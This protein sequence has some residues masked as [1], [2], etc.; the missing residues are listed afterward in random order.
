MNAPRTLLVACIALAPLSAQTTWS[1]CA[2]DAPVR[3]VG[4][5]TTTTVRAPWPAS[6]RLPAGDYE[7]R[8][9]ADAAGRPLA[10]AFSVPDGAA[11]RVVAA[12]AP[13]AAAVYVALD[14]P[15]WRAAGDVRWIADAR[16]EVLVEA[17]YEEAA[18]VFG[19][20]ARWNGEH[21]HYRFVEDRERNELRLER[22]HGDMVLVLARAPASAASPG[23][24]RLAL[25]VVGF[26]LVALRDD[27]VVLQS[28]DGAFAA[29]G[30]GLFGGPGVTW[31]SFSIAPPAAS[32]DSAAAVVSDGRVDLRVATIA[33]P[34]SWHV[35][36]LSLD[37]PGP[38]APT[39]SAGLAPWL[40]LAA[41]ERVLT[42]DLRGTLGE[43]TVGEVPGA[44]TFRTTLRWPFLPGLSGQF[45]VVRALFVAA[46]GRA[47]EGASPG[48]PLVF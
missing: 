38:L 48:V 3:I 8:F 6:V 27:A 43:G 40:L 15:E 46:D 25:Q 2:G 11:V 5:A 23:P 30:C 10:T 24:H 45:V 32:R 20:V 17:A 21:D 28:L 26:R 41:G 22:R 9:A 29:G 35:L 36:E 42:G 47:V 19:V 14:A 34:G 31:R 13:A 12:P 37:R 44:G 1:L 4:T 33:V 7:V 39:D 18:G 16:P